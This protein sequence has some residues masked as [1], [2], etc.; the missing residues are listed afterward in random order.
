MRKES[1][2]RDIAPIH[3]GEHLAEYLEEMGII[4]YRLS[5][6][7]H[8]PQMRISEIV[9]GKRA[10]TADT[11]LRFGRFFGTSPQFW[12]NM[13]TQY[14]LETAEDVIGSALDEVHEYQQA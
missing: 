1:R 6:E 2:K 11:A 12:L 7:L 8:V 9:R 10:I 14:D 3:P 5:K 4:Q 13:Q